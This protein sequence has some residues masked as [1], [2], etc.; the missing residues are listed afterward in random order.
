MNKPPKEV[1]LT[2]RELARLTGSSLRKIREETINGVTFTMC[3]L[4]GVRMPLMEARARLKLKWNR[5]AKEVS[6]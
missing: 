6:K 5:A 1:E 4:D 2:D 3:E